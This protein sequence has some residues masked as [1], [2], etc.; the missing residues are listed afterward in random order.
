MKIMNF[1]FNLTF[2]NKICAFC[3]SLRL[4]SMFLEEADISDFAITS[5]QGVTC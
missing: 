4:S 3:Q 2:L 5:I 1:K